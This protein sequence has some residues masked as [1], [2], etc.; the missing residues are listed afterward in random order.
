VP[1]AG[2]AALRSL[3]RRHVLVLLGALLREQGRSMHIVRALGLMTEDAITDEVMDVNPFRGVRVRANDP[4]GMKGRGRR[5][6]SRS[7]KCTGS[8]R[9]R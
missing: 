8:P 9:Q 3:R 7:S 2:V 1:A 5:A 4:R 6:C